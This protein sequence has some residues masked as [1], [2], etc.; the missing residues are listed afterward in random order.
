LKDKEIGLVVPWALGE[1]GDKSAIPALTEMLSDNDLS[2]RAQATR[3][4]VP[5]VE[6]TVSAANP[7]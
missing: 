7:R 5:T 2:M 3:A 4:L 1:I 6:E